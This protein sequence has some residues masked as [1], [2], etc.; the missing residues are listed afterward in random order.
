MGS[1]EQRWDWS[2][3]NEVTGVPWELVPGQEGIQIR[4]SVKLSGEDQPI[5]PPT[6]VQSKEYKPWGAQIRIADIIQ[7]GSTMNNITRI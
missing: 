3:F 5:L 6:P 1:H 4:S 2:F 7:H